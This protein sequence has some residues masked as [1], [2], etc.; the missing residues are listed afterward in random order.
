M[1]ATNIVECRDGL[2]FFF[3]SRAHAE[4]L[5]SFL[6]SV[7]PIRTKHSKQLISEDTHRGKSRNKS[8]YSAEVL[9]ICKDDLVWLPPATAASL[10]HLPQLALA[11][12]IS[13]VLHL[14]DPQSLQATPPR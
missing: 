9:P 2:D 7:V 4:K 3:E 5:V 14:L 12:K 6:S 10:G 8:S 11:S 1:D 13:N